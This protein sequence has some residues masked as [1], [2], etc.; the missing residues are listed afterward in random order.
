MARS[1]IHPGLIF[2]IGVNGIFMN[3]TIGVEKAAV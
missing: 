2:G 1:I 3:L